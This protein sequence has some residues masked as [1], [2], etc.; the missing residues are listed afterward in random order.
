MFISLHSIAKNK[1][2]LSVAEIMKSK[3]VPVSKRSVSYKLK[4]E[5]NKGYGRSYVTYETELCFSHDYLKR[6]TRL[7]L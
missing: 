2:V 1:G 6:V 5:A 3:T 7:W 4:T